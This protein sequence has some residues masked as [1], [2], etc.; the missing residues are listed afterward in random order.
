MNYAIIDADGAYH[1]RFS[2]DGSMIIALCR[3]ELDE[4][5]LSGRAAGLGGV[6]SEL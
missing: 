1:R 3:H 5:A 4:L 6:V 2:R